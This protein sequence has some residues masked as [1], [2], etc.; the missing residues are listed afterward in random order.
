MSFV[1]L[2]AQSQLAQRRALQQLATSIPV[3]APAPGQTSGGLTNTN[4]TLSVVAGTIAPA[5]SATSPLVYT[6]SGT[7][8]TLTLTTGAGLTVSGGSLAAV[9]TGAG[10]GLSLI[11]GLITSPIQVVSNGITLAGVTLGLTTTVQAELVGSATL[12]ITFGSNTIGI[13]LTSGLTSTS[14]ALAV[15]LNTAGALVFNT[16][17]S[18]GVNLLLTGTG[19]GLV[20]NTSNQ[21]RINC[22][23]G[24]NL[25][26]TPVANTIGAQVTGPVAVQ[27]SLNGIQANSGGTLGAA[28]DNSTIKINGSGQLFA[29]A[30]GLQTTTLPVTNTTGTVGLALGYNM[31]V[32][33]TSSLVAIST[34]GGT[35]GATSS[36]LNRVST[37][38]AVVTVYVYL[39]SVSLSAAG[40]SV[41]CTITVDGNSLMVTA[42]YPG[43]GSTFSTTGYAVAVFHLTGSGGHGILHMQIDTN[44]S[45]I[46]G[47]N[48][49]ASIDNSIGSAPS[50]STINIS[51]SAS[52]ATVS[53]VV[54]SFVNTA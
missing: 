16:G 39:S 52:N 42:N 9:V 45:L 18:V 54:A 31:T 26:S 35:S 40:G 21:L 43:L 13:T 2:N 36:T 14:G 32:D 44:T 46:V 17:G 6:P 29:V 53:D 19:S 30:S 11:G 23:S 51:A 50:G 47:N 10:L 34:G 25:L 12:P 22:G 8:G 3:L 24:L 27:G 5:L 37:G 28:V 7:V 33:A 38:G 49:S 20:I 41:S 15:A 1:N 48:V 4:G